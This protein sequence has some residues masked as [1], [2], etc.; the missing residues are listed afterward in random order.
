M[1]Y[2][3]LQAPAQAEFIERKSRFISHIFP[4]QEEAQALQ[5]L[6]RIRREYWDASHHVYA[7][8]LR[9]AGTQRY[10]DDGEPQGTAGVP[11]LEVLQREGLT[12]VLVVVTR[13]FGGIL[14]GGGGLVRAYSHSAALAAH[15]AEKKRMCRCVPLEMKVD[16]ALYGKLQALLPAFGVQTAGCEFL[17]AVH[18]KLLIREEELDAFQKQLL[19]TSAGALRPEAGEARFAPF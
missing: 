2:V 10:S 18:M 8:I 11:V 7:Y 14:L 3:T 1:E 5:S 17:D 16:Y 15:A 13:Y 4:V 9:Q 19:E 12:D 6:E